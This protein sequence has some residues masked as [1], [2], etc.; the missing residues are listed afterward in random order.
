MNIFVFI[1]LFLAI[2]GLIDKI[3]NNKLGLVHSFDKGIQSM[4]T[5]A[6]SMMGF[7]CIAVTFV[8]QNVDMIFAFSKLLHFDPNVIVGCLLAP[9]LGGYS[10]V[11]Q[12]STDG[13]LTLF[14]GLIMT[15]TIGTV[16]SFQLP[17]FFTAL[18]KEDI[19]PYIKGLIYGIVAVPF[20]LIPL[21]VFLNINNILFLL[22]PV[23]I[24]CAILILGLSFLKKQTMKFL[25]YFGEIIRIIS[26]IFFGFVIAG[27]YLNDFSLTSIE[28]IQEALLI[29]F[30][31]TMV[32]TG[33]M[34][35]CD[36]CLKYFHLTIDKIA[37]GLGINS[38]SVIGLFLQMATSVAMFPLF[39]KMDTKGKIINGAFSVSGA[40]VIGAQLGF[41]A[42]VTSHQGVMIYIVTKLCAGFLAVLLA[43]VFQKKATI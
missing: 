38:Y 20:I 14:I 13:K 27:A 9:D 18:N 36:L 28:L 17:L 41:A 24:L 26:L 7:Y 31:C 2:L 4:S 34:I 37:K 42:S 10:I 8:N 22:L 35:L 11:S 29:V 15:S 1:L 3:L 30:K 23:F 25:I 6:L 19:Q 12:L 40:Y 16:I 21:G 43:F 32:V 5:L 39:S 33:S